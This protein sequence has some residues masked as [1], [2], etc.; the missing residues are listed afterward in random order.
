MLRKYE[1]ELRRLKQELD[2]RSANVDSHEQILQLEKEKRRAE[3]DKNAAIT[4]LEM[5]SREFM[6]EKEQKKLLE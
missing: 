1:I 4:A 5:R 2:T 6:Q 3:E